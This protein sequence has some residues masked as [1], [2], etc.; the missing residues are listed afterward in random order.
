MQLGHRETR[1]AFALLA[2]AATATGAAAG[3]PL[4]DT[5]VGWCVDTAAGT[6]GVAC[7]GTGQDGETGRDV[8][9][10]HPKNGPLGFDFVKVCNSG[11]LA[12]EGTC[13]VRPAQGPGPDD[14][15]C[16]MDRHTGLVWE[17]RTHDGGL[18]DASKKYTNLGGGASTDASGLVAAVNAQGLCG[19]SDW[20]MPTRSE[21]LGKLDLGTRVRNF[22]DGD[23]FPDNM[24]SFGEAGSYWT[25]QDVVWDPGEGWAIDDSL[26]QVYVSPKSY[27][28]NF[29]RLVREPDPHTVSPRF[30]VR[31]QQVRDAQTRLVWRHC[32]EGM[33]WNGTTCKGK[34]ELYTWPDALAHAQA[35]AA[36]S[37]QAWRVPNVKELE[38]L[39]DPSVGYPSI[40]ATIFPGTPAQYTW[41]S[42]PFSI[43]GPTSAYANIVDFGTGVV[44]ID[45]WTVQRPV[46]LVRDPG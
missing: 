36:K 38:S 28:F 1:A 42:S 32:V 43:G 3:S 13:G 4:D 8:T 39:V 46:R 34:P 2:L 40:D 15:G 19:A 7:A 30:V 11:Q 21:L 14:W 5:G 41:T 17:L 44:Y 23:W 24:N 12:G 35:A 45:A 20:R 26:A 37:G 9:A 33:A 31:G 29:V 22:D 18:I 27:Q 25:S 10:N 16:T 6:I